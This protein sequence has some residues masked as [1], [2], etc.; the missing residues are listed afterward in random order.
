MNINQ[1]LD[2]IIKNHIIC[3][4][5]KKDEVQQKIHKKVN[6]EKEKRKNREVKVVVVH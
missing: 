5:I 2:H 1:N 3:T 6:Q 4:I